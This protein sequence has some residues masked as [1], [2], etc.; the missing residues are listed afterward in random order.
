M[1][2]VYYHIPEDGDT[3]Q[4]PNMFAIPEQINKLTLEHIHQYFPL[5]GTYVFRFK[6]AFDNFI[7]WLDLAELSQ[8][9]PTFKNQIHLKANRLSWN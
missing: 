2:L 5:K 1:T 3:S 4:E 8:S 7:V 9:P 6:V